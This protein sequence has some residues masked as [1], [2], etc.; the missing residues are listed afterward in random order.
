[1]SAVAASPTSMSTN[2]RP[3]WMTLLEG[4]I[5]AILGAVLLFGSSQAKIDTWLLVVTFIGVYWLVR[6]I[7][8]IVSMFMD[9]TAWG[10]KLFMGIIGILAG[11]SI[12]M[13]PVAAAIALPQIFGLV[14]GIWGLVQGIVLLIMA[15]RGGGW[16][17]GILGGIGILFGL[18][19]IANYGALFQGLA[20]LWTA[21][22]FA[23]IGGIVLIVQSFRARSA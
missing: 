9:H 23:L 8:D 6:G 11:G 20:F 7:M 18:I 16:G 13:Y 21:A 1:M 14:I 17:T 5:L 3:W 4:I 22:L 2:Q 19:L 15:F 12:I 10:W